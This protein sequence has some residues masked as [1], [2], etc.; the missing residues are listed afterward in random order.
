MIRK[1]TRVVIGLIGFILGIT[2]YLTLMENFPTLKFGTDMYGFIISGAVGIIVGLL[3]YAVEPW[4]INKIKEAAKM[5]DKE[6]SKYPQTD[7]LL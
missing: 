3:F 7:I 5:M 2:T 6:I 1:V 4:I